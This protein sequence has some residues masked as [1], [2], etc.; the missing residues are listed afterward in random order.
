MRPLLPRERR[1]LLCLAI[2]ASGASPLLLQ[3]C[4]VTQWQ[5]LQDVM[6]Q[7]EIRRAMDQTRSPEF[8]AAVEHAINNTGTP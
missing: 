1:R 3:G 8:R 2:L 5:K 4:G 7:P 6:G